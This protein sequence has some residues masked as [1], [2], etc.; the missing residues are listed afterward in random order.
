[1]PFVEKRCS[2]IYAT[3]RKES[4]MGF[5]RL[6]LSIGVTF[7]AAFTRGSSASVNSST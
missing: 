5:Q 1:L 2:V 6:G 4:A 7:I 3:I